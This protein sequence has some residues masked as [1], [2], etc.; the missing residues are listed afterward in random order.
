MPASTAPVLAGDIGGTK[1]LLRVVRFGG[2]PHGTTLYQRRFESGAYDDLESMAREFL[3]GAPAE[4]PPRAACFGVAGPVTGPPC[5]ERA[6][7]TNLPWRLDA[8]ELTAKLGMP[9]RL[10][11][12]FRAVGYAIEALGPVDLA[13]LHTAPTEP[14]GP[15]V[16]LGAGTGLGVALLFWDGNHY[17][18]YPT[19]GGHADFAPTGEVQDELL[20]Y[21]RTIHGRVSYER[22]LSG[23]GL[24]SI[25]RFL[26]ERD[27]RPQ[28]GDTILDAPD[29]AAAVSAQALTRSDP[30][31]C[32]AL[33]LFI[34]IYGAAAGNLALTCLATGGVYVAG[35]IAPKILDRLYGGVFIEA[36]LA[37]GRMRHLVERM[38][39]HVVTNS[40]AGLI[41]ASLAAQRL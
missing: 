31:A 40:E 9:V 14:Q 25:Y 11:N 15:R 19:E 1:T 21:L 22:I 10:I 41:G 12:D 33:D 7:L 28:A 29:P 36:Y 35:G 18:A 38:P 3:R 24:E 17:E 8:V 6:R 16:V 26:L 30:L 37:K 5:A 39:V 20:R 34:E 23:P 2:E 27:R 32:A 4:L 13:A